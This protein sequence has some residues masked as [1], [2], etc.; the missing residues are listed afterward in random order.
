MFSRFD[1]K[2]WI[3]RYNGRDKVCIQS[4]IN[5]HLLSYWTLSCTTVV[6]KAVAVNQKH[7][8]EPLHSQTYRQKL[9]PAL[10]SFSHYYAHNRRWL[11]NS[12]LKPDHLFLPASL[13]IYMTQSYNWKPR[14]S[15]SGVYKNKLINS[16][17]QSTLSFVQHVAMSSGV[18]SPVILFPFCM[19]T[20]AFISHTYKSFSEQTL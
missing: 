11:W 15:V 16:C 18:L 6:I 12:Y 20:N 7:R 13:K 19:L 3:W 5:P 14:F 17:N 2:L 10:K 8:R 4:L 9:T 1:F